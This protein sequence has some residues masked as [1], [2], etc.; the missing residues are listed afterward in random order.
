M[1][2]LRWRHEVM[3]SL[4]AERPAA[5]ELAPFVRVCAASAEDIEKRLT[6]GLDGL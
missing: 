6:S 4:V 3:A 2:H 5:D 1:V